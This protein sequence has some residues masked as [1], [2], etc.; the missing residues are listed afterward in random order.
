LKPQIATGVTLKR[1]GL[2][3]AASSAD[4]GTTTAVA[5]KTQATAAIRLFFMIVIS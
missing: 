3:P 2:A 4:A 5:T 1:H